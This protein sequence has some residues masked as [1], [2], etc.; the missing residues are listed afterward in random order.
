MKSGIDDT[1]ETAILQF[2]G[3][4][5]FQPLNAKFFRLLQPY[6]Y[7]TRIP[8]NYIYIYSFSLKP[9]EHQPTGTCN[10]SQLKDKRLIL[11]MKNK[12]KKSDFIIKVYAVN[13]NLLIITEGMAGI[14]FS[15]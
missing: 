10:F 15:C 13:Y 4:N 12:R 8:T 14:G 11:N 6:Y 2:N 7:H 3:M 9:E 5:R 1:F